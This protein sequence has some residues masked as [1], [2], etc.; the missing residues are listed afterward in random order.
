MTPRIAPVAQCLIL[1]VLGLALGTSC[2]PLPEFVNMS[3]RVLDD[4]HAAALPEVGAE[5]RVLD[6]QLEETDLVLTDDEG[7]FVAEVRA[8]GSVYIELAAEG[9]TRTAFSWSSGLQ[10]FSLPSDSLWLVSDEDMSELRGEFL[11]CPQ[12][13]QPEGS[14]IEGDVRVAISGYTLAEGELWPLSNSANITAY[15]ASGQ[16]WPACYLDEEGGAYDPEAQVTG[17]SG[18]FAVFDG[19]TGPVTIEA[20]LFNEG[21]LVSS[22]LMYVYVAEDGVAP[23]YSVHVALPGQ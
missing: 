11:G 3:G 14:V 15:D 7:V 10:D 1:S 22:T 5:V 2:Q 12:A 17:A 4:R 23:M 20:L 21:E 6:Q 9:F 13:D 16:A 8:G 18:R 19:P